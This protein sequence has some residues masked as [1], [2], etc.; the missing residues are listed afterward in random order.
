MTSKKKVLV[1]AGTGCTSSGAHKIIDLLNQEIIRQGLTER[2]ETVPTG[3]QGFCEQGPTLVIEPDQTLYTLVNPEDVPEIVQK[4]FGEGERVER[5][6]Y[7][8]PL[9]GQAAKDYKTTQFFA[10]QHRIVLRNCGLI[11]PTKLEDYLANDG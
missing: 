6:L 11:D 1:C 5:L 9:T 7:V 8:D 2:V 4:E 10:K 3:C